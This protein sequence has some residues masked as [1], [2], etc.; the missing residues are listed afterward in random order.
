[1]LSFGS[2]LALLKRLCRLLPIVR[3]NRFL[4]IAVGKVNQDPVEVVVKVMKLFAR[5][6]KSQFVVIIG[7]S[8]KNWI[9]KIIWIR[10]TFL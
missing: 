7:F 1:M 3:L 4:A 8:R 2:S 9:E 10:A 5:D 6:S